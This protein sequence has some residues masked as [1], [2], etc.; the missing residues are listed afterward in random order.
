[1]TNSPFSNRN[2]LLIVLGVFVLALIGVGFLVLAVFLLVRGPGSVASQSASQTLP[3]VVA[4]QVVFVPTTTEIPPTD[5]LEPTV[6]P[7]PTTPPPA[8]SNTPVVT[9][10]AAVTSNVVTVVSP[11]NVRS[12]PG[13]T[14]PVIAGLNTGQTAPVVGRDSSAQW[15]AISVDSAP[16]GTGWISALVASY[17]GTVSDLPVVQASAPPPPQAT[18]VPPTNPPPPTSPP[19]PAGPTNTPVVGGA[20]GIQTIKFDMHQTTGAPNQSMFFDFSV[21]NVSGST[22][23]G[24]GI[25]AAHTDQGVTADSWHAPLLPGKQLNWTDHINFPN[26]GTYQVYLGICYSSHDACKTGGAPW[27]RLSNSVTVTIQ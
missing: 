19:Q 26:T 3:A 21:V 10:T 27:T 17:D 13:L 1:M 5:T 20:N 18:A 15:F 25:L 8:P 23:S 6:A 9:A 7:T 14:Y 16:G 24:Y 22:I 4:T 2:N 11:A 12:G